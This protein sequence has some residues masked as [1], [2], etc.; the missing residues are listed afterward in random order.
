MPLINDGSILMSIKKLLNVEHDDQAFDLDIG[1]NIHRKTR[2]GRE[3]VW[4]ISVY[5]V[6]CRINPIYATFSYDSTKP[7][8]VKLEGVS[9]GFIPII[10]TFSYTLR[11]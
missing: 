10:P 4:N 7:E 5:N 1:M 8:E 6:Y 11:F 2:H 3:V 9:H